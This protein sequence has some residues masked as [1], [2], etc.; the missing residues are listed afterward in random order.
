MPMTKVQL[1]YDLL[2]PIDDQIMEQISKAHGI[3][4]IHRITL[5]ESLDKVTI[6]YDASR[7]SPLEIEQAMHGLGIPVAV[8]A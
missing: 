8:R 7:L 2:R 3:Y 4:G 6:E 1:R 5:A